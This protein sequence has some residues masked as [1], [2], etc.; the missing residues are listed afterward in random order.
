MS[1]NPSVE[2]D[3]YERYGLKWA[4]FPT[5]I[6]PSAHSDEAELFCAKQSMAVYGVY[7][8]LPHA[9]D[10][11]YV[12][13]RNRE[14]MEAGTFA[15]ARMIEGAGDVPAPSFEGEQGYRLV[16]SD[17]AGALLVWRNDHLVI[18][19]R[20]TA[21]WQDWI[22]NFAGDRIV[23]DLVGLNEELELHK[24]FTGLAVN[25][26]P[27]VHELIGEFLKMRGSRKPPP[28]LT[29]CGHSL[30]G[31]LALN[32]AAR[33]YPRAD[34]RGWRELDEYPIRVGATYTFGAPRIGKGPV[35]RYIRRPH[36]RLIV[37]GDPVPRAPPFC[38]DDYEAT[39]FE[40]PSSEAKQPKNTPLKILKAILA[41]WKPSFDVSAH[42]IENYID[43]I[44]LKIDAKSGP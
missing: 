39:Y 17:R 12:P 28:I 40:K 6:T 23:Q 22:H 16:V 25:I 20:G 34:Y 30:G 36:Y 42:D 38:T 14:A 41:R 43:A 35:W 37:H 5:L 3:V 44:Q 10:H 13:S 9:P 11:D 19:F 27:A 31:A 7:P 4:D 26:A 15:V 32:F 2:N 1:K 29:L 33:M 21:N 24:G 18:A 8:H